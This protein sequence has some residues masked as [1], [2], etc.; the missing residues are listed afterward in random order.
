MI[1]KTRKKYRNQRAG[2]EYSYGRSKRKCPRVWEEKD[3]D[4]GLFSNYVPK[5]FVKNCS[6]NAERTNIHF[7]TRFFNCN[8]QKGVTL[9]SPRHANGDLQKNFISDVFEL[10]KARD[11][12]HPKFDKT[13]LNRIFTKYQKLNIDPYVK[14]FVID[15][16][17]DV[18]EMGRS[19]DPSAEPSPGAKV[20]AKGVE[21]EKYAQFSKPP[22]EEELMDSKY[23][24][25][26]I[27]RIEQFKL[28]LQQHKGYEF[29]RA[30]LEK[31]LKESMKFFERELE[32]LRKEGEIKVTDNI[33]KNAIN[34]IA[35]RVEQLSS[36][37]QADEYVKYASNRYKSRK[38]EIVRDSFD[39]KTVTERA[40]VFIK[41]MLDEVDDN[42]NEKNK[43]V[44]VRRDNSN[45]GSSDANSLLKKIRSELNRRKHGYGNFFYENYKNRPSRELKEWYSK[46]KNEDIYQIVNHYLDRSHP[47]MEGFNENNSNYESSD[48]D[49]E[50]ERDEIKKIFRKNYSDYKELNRALIEYDIGGFDESDKESQRENYRNYLDFFKE[51]DDFKF[52][53]RVH[54]KFN[55]YKYSK[56]KLTMFLPEIYE[57]FE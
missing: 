45:I 40:K 50:D 2:S 34:T 54:R 12:L 20:Q 57:K 22:K 51:S 31:S 1:N 52:I 6:C 7:D 15:Y 36:T 43:T 5:A 27:N 49:L 23:F 17:Q 42:E 11:P 28:S 53:K 8:K 30:K 4:T 29:R 38:E 9:K 41:Q 16:I 18:M 33:F 10:Y 14:Q 37:R 46:K 39:K 56:R 19:F 21:G 32:I 55:E 24:D 44:R 26:I 13:L 47:F 25:K 35:A 3:I 48:D